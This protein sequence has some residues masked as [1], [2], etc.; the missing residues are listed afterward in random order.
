MTSDFLQSILQISFF[1]WYKRDRFK[2]WKGIESVERLCRRPAG[3]GASHPNA[4]VGFISSM[5]PFDS[6]IEPEAA[7]KLLYVE[8]GRRVDTL[9][10]PPRT[11]KSTC[12]PL[13]VMSC[14]I[15]SSYL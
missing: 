5:K 10:L 15:L 9:H 13:S 3:A 6:S 1:V 11:L 8:T 4:G 12:L 7:F 14:S 2:E